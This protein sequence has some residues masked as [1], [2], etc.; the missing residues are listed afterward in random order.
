MIHGV[1]LGGTKRQKTQP[2]TAQPPLL[3]QGPGTHTSEVTQTPVRQRGGEKAA[4]LW[5]VLRLPP[6]SPPQ[7][8]ATAPTGHSLL[9]PLSCPGGDHAGLSSPP[10]PFGSDLMSPRVHATQEALAQ[11]PSAREGHR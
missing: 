6:P 11:P 9:P 7:P 1:G 4:P 3:P 10:N 2:V 8:E 5:S